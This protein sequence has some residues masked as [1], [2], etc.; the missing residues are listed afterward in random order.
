MTTKLGRRAALA[1][2]ALGL[3]VTA[4]AQ[5]APLKIGFITTL[6]GPAGYL[7]A[8]IRDGFLLA[9]NDGKLGGVPVDLVIEDDGLKPAQAK[10]IAARF[11]KS[12]KIKLF[13]G[14][15]FS[16]VLQAVA[17]DLF[18]EEAIYVSPNAGPSDFAGKGCNANYYV[19]SWQN[20]TLHEAAGANATRLGYKKIFVL[21]AN[22]QAGKDAVTGFKRFF[23]GEIAGELYTKLDQTDFSAEMAQIRDA[24][25]DAVYQ[26]EPG[27][28]GIAFIR[29]YQQA[30]LL[31]KIPLVLGAPSLDS[32][33]L[34]AV[35]DAA[36]GINLASHWNTDFTNDANKKFVPAFQAR[37]NR[38]PT[39]YASQGYDT[40]QA[41]GA[42][43]AGTGGN[44]SDT[45]AFRK[46]ML[47]ANFESV[48]GKFRF[49]PNQ[50]PIQDWYALQVVRGADGKLVMRTGEKVLS[51]RGDAYS[52]E[53]HL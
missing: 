29:Q 42:A 16:N 12:E 5:S 14:I 27:G 4:R 48:R 8:D 43:L 23:K 44:V 1:L 22:Y 36:L 40:A 20:D 53:C 35:G 47:P 25:P 9:L 21:A 24:A 34:A 17:P 11:L 41:I 45:A 7:G 30:G 6:S 37:Y 19:V 39:W 32:T 38:L 50:S 18:D 33:I 51:D 28:L 2:P 49:G 31:E 15:V 10:Q 52:A 26:F 46:A 13:T 3:F